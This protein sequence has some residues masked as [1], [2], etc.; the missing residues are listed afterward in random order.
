MVRFG[1]PT[2]PPRW[3]PPSDGAKPGLWA[4]QPVQD[5]EPPTVI[6]QDWARTPIDHFILAKLEDKGIQPSAPAEKL[7]LLRRAKYD[8]HGLPPSEQEIEEFLS[9]TAP[10]A[11]ARLVDRLLASPRYGEKWGRHWLD[12]AR[13]AD[14]TGLD[15]DYR[16]PHSWRYRDYV[17]DAF[18]R[19]LPFDQF[20]REQLA[21]DL[22]PADEPG[23]INTRGIVATGFLALGVKALAQQDKKK[24]IYDVVD[25]QID[26]V[27][28]AFMGLTITCARCH[29]HKFDPILTKDYYSLASIFASTKSFEDV[30][31]FVSKV[32]LAPLVEMPV[33]EAYRKAQDQIQARAY[34]IESIRELGV[35]AYVRRDLSPRLPDYMVAARRVYEDDQPLADTAARADLDAEILERWVEYL[36]PGQFRPYLENWE[37]AKPSERVAAAA[38]YRELYDKTSQWWD[39]EVKSWGT[40]AQDAISAGSKAP[41]K[42]EFAGGEIGGITG[43]FF[44]EVG[45]GEGPFSVTEEDRDAVLS[46][47]V[48][49]RLASLTEELEAWK[50]AS[51]A[52]PP[53]AY[54]VTEGE[55][56]EQHVFIGGSYE[57]PGELAPKDVP[58]VL[59]GSRGLSIESG[60][61]RMELAEWLASPDHP[62]TA[63]VYVNRVW[64]WHFGEGLVRTPN[65]MGSTGEQPTHPALLDYLAKRFVESG[66]S[67]KTLHRMI[68]LS[69]AYQMSSQATEDVVEAD[70]ENRLWSHF[71][72]RRLTVEEMRDS[73][74]ALDGTLD[75]AMGGRIDDGL[76]DDEYGPDAT[77]NPD[78]VSRR[79]LYLP[80]VR[81]KLPSLLRLFNFADTGAS[82]GQRNESNIAPQA[83]YAMNSDFVKSRAYALAEIVVRSSED[84][85]ERVERA[86]RLILGRGPGEGAEPDIEYVRS[87]PAG[88][89][90]GADAKLAAWASLC[91]ILMASNEFHYID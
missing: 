1:P 49:E 61:G 46:S 19:D 21:G 20:V 58:L 63:R 77:F 30:D 4:F 12:V 32:Y 75:L 11:M 18:N 89:A 70:P 54:G 37:K 48:Q 50:E 10:E 17:V 24:V 83:L 45:S 53:L 14:S 57:S 71:L 26:T 3:P 56:V 27:S 52:E 42:P 55:V 65:N 74:L 72:R 66:W 16:L 91:R 40:Q 87:Y 29:D 15:E 69:S 25:D 76:K 79:T 41:D 13:Y 8:L 90:E 43:R 9:D 5:H 47:S 62:L 78:S 73:F 82:S 39:D 88:E 86:Y 35:S 7:Q 60:S 67:T 23:E 59:R 84:D 31:S 33:Y 28:K 68:M 80:L 36:R 81:N 85:S 6:D 44:L 51:P 38:E 34:T 22:M 2:T 64:Q